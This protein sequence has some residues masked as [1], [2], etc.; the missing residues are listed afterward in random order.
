[1][2]YRML[3]ALQVLWEA[4]SPSKDLK[5]PLRCFFDGSIDYFQIDRLGGVVTHLLK[6]HQQ[7]LALLL[8]EDHPVFTPKVSSQFALGLG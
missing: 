2:F 4:E 6:E 7:E 5:M 8:G 1:M 3:T